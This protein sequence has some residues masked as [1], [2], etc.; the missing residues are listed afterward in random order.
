M[1][2]NIPDLCHTLAE[3]FR[4]IELIERINSENPNAKLT[5]EILG[6]PVDTTTEAERMLW[7]EGHPATLYFYQMLLGKNVRRLAE[8]AAVYERSPKTPPQG[9]PKG[10]TSRPGFK[11]IPPPEPPKPAE[12]VQKKADPSRALLGRLGSD[13][14]HSR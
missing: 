7:V 12:P 13:F 3:F 1:R 9:M 5:Y 8:T 2:A 11:R 4:S 6:G 10:Y 14:F